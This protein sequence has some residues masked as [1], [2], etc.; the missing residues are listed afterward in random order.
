MNICGWLKRLTGS[1]RPCDTFGN[2]CLAHTSEFQLKNVE[3]IY[4][5]LGLWLPL[6]LIYVLI[7]MQLLYTDMSLNEERSYN[8]SF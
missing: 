5:S 1:S 6:D 4:L 2:M 3:V 7:L 8:I